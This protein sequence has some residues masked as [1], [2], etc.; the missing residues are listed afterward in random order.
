MGIDQMEIG[1]PIINVFQFSHN[2][3]SKSRTCSTILVIFNVLSY[4][5][6]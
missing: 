5:A 4:F 3:L 6:I 2:V 1:K